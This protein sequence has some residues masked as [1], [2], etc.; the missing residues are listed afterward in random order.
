MSSALASGV[1]ISEMMP[2]NGKT[3]H[4][5]GG[6]FPD[7]VEIKNEA[8]FPVELM[9]HGL[10]PDPAR[11]FLFTFP[12]YRLKPGEWVV[13]F[14]SG[15]IARS[16]PIHHEL[17]LEKPML[18]GEILHLD[19]SQV[20][21]FVFGKNGDIQQWLDR[22]PLGLDT[23]QAQAEKAPRRV[24]LTP[25]KVP[26]V[27]FDGDDD[28]LKMDTLHGLRTVFWVGAEHPAASDHFRPILGHTTDYPMVR[29]SNK[30]LMHPLH[31]D[32][33][34][35][36]GVFQNGQRIDALTQAAPVSLSL[37]RFQSDREKHFNLLGSDRLLDN[38][39]WHGWFSELLLY[40][41]VL[42]PM[43]TS[44]IEN[45]LM[46]RWGLPAS[47][48]HAPFRIKNG[49]GILTLSGPDGRRLDTFEVKTTLKDASL[50]RDP[51]SGQVH[52][53]FHP[54][55][56]TRND[57][58]TF[59]GIL[60]EVKASQQG[61]AYASAVI[62]AL[63]HP[64][65][66]A[67]IRYTLDGDIPD[68]NALLYQKPLS[69]G[70]T[71]VLKA[72]AF[73]LAYR[74]GPCMVHTYLI[75][76]PTSIPVISLSGPPEEWFSPSEGIY[77]K[78]PAASP[79]RPY[80]GAN[81]WREWERQVEVEWIEPSGSRWFRQTVGAKIHGAWSRANPQKS[82]ALVARSS[83][84]DNRFRGTIFEDRQQKTFKQ[85]L[86]RNG[87][88]DWALAMLRDALGQSFMAEM[89]LDTQAYRPVHVMINGDYF[90]LHN[91]RERANE[92]LL[93]AHRGIPKEQIDLVGGDMNS[94]SG[95]PNEAIAF[96]RWIAQQK[97]SDP[98]FEENLATRIDIENFMDYI[99]GQVCIDNGDWPGNNV[100]FWR[101]RSSS[102]RWRWL[103]YDLDGGFDPLSEVR[104]FDT[105]EHLLESPEFGV[106]S[107]LIPIT[108]NPSLRQRFIIR[109]QNHL[110]TVFSSSN[111]IQRID[112][113]AHGIKDEMPYHLK[114]WRGRSIG[115]I[116]F[117]S[118]LQ[119][120]ESNVEMMRRFARSREVIVRNHLEES[121]QLQPAVK[122]SFQLPPLEMGQIR[123]NGLPLPQGGSTPWA[124]YFFQEYGINIS[125]EPAF[126]FEFHGWEGH[127]QNDP[128]I[129]LF[130]SDL[131]ALTPLFKPVAEPVFPVSFGQIRLSEIMYHPASHRPDEEFI[132]LVNTDDHPIDMLGWRLDRGV[133]YTFPSHV[134]EPG[135]YLVVAANPEAY[136]QV[137]PG[138]AKPLGPWTGQLSNA[139]E[140]IRLRNAAN[141][142]VDVL[143]YADE[144]DWS[145]RVRGPT[146][147]GHQGWTWS[148]AHDGDGHS[149][150]RILLI[151][152]TQHPQN[153]KASLA[154]HG[155]PG[156]RNSVRSDKIG[157]LLGEISHAPIVPGSHQEVWV[158][159][160]VE[161]ITGDLHQVELLYRADGDASFETVPMQDDGRLEDRFA[162]D[163][164]Y[165][166][167][168]PGFANQT[169]VEFWVRASDQEGLVR[170][171]PASTPEGQ[172]VNALYQVDDTLHDPFKPVVR[173]ITTEAERS[174][175]E[176]IGQL[177][178]NQTSDAQ[179]NATF[180]IEEGGKV[181]LR[182]LAGLRLRGST[183]RALSPKNRRVNFTSQSPWRGRTSVIF[184]AINVPSQVLGSAL[185]RAAGVPA[186]DCRPVVFL[187]NG[188]NHA[189]VGF[190]QFGCYAQSEP[191]DDLFTRRHFQ[192][193]GNLYRPFG[194]GNLEYLGADPFA[195]QLPGFYHK[196]NHVEKNDWSDLM[197]LTRVLSQAPDLAYEAAVEKVVH[198]D[199][200]LRYFAMDT[201][202]ANME[203]SFA[204]GGAG[205]YAL[206]IGAEDGRATL[207]PYDLDS[208][209]G[210][211]I[212]GLDASIF[213]ATFQE[214]PARFL[215]S[216]GFARAYH[217]LLERLCEELFSPERMNPLLE[218]VLGDWTD[219]AFVSQ[220]QGFISQRR[221][222]VLKQIPRVLS[223]EVNLPFA[224]P[225]YLRYY[226]TEEGTIALRG[227][228]NALRTAKILVQG[229]EAA[230]SALEGQWVM[231]NLPVHG[232]IN[233]IV[234]QALDLHG[235][236][237]EEQRIRVLHEGSKTRQYAGKLQENLVWMPG[238]SPIGVT[239][240]LIIPEGLTLTVLPG[241]SV[242]F[243]AD[244]G[245]LVRG[246][247]Q[248]L[249]TE[250]HRVFFSTHRFAKQRW[251]G[252]RFED[253]MQPSRLDYVT[254]EWSVS[255]GIQLNHARLDMTGCRW[256]GAYNSFIL[257]QYSSLA[258]RG[259][260]FPNVTQGEP[261]GGIGIPEEGY[262]I[263][264]DCEFGSTTGYADIIDFTGGHLPGPVPQ[265]LNN[266]FLG[267]SDDGLDLDGSDAYIEGNVFMGFHKNN[268]S[269]SESHAIATGIYDGVPSN[270]TVVRNIFV[271]NDHDILLKEW[272][273][274]YVGHNTFVGARLATVSLQES[275]RQTH[276]PNALTLEGNII[277]AKRVLHAYDDVMALRPD[278][279][280]SVRHCILPESWDLV[281]GT[282]DILP[283][284]FVDRNAR[285]F[286][287]LP[288]S[289]VRGLGPLG[290]NPG[291]D[292]PGG[293]LLKGTPWTVLPGYPME[294]DVGGPGIVAFQYRMDAGKWSFPRPVSEPISVPVL[295]DGIHRL[296][297]VVQNAA[298]VWL[299]DERDRLKTH[300]Q[301]LA[302]ASPVRFSEVLAHPQPSLTGGGE[303][304][305]LVNLGNMPH[306]LKGYS[307]TDDP[308]DPMRYVFSDQATIDPGQ[309]L[310]LGDLE[311]LLAHV[312]ILPFR[313]SKRGESIHLYRSFGNT[314]EQVDSVDFGWQAQGWSIG[315]GPAGE[316]S[317]NLPSPGDINRL[318]LMGPADGVELSEWSPQGN[319]QQKE[320]FIELTHH[321]NLPV[322]LSWWTLGREPHLGS[323][324]LRLPG[325]TFM[326]PGERRVM[327]PGSDARDL[328]QRLD[329]EMDLWS[330]V[331]LAGN[332]VDR[333]WYA[334]PRAGMSFHRSDP[335]ARRVVQ[336]PPT[337]GLQDVEAGTVNGAPV[338]HEIAADNRTQQGPETT[339]AD[340]LELWNPT[341]KPVHLEGISLSDDL[342][343]PF[344]WS[345]PP[346]IT[347]PPLGYGIVWMDGS[348]KPSGQNTGFSLKS[349]GDQLWMH[350]TPARGGGLL[351]LVDFGVQVP[352]FTIGR[353]S[354]SMQW[355]LTEPSPGG[356]NIPVIQGEPSAIRINEW[357]A[358]PESG[359]DWFELFN[360]SERPIP[361][362]GL[363]LSDDPLDISKHVFPAL[364]YLGTGSA[365]YLLM[366][367][368]GK[369]NR[370]R[371]VAFKLSSEGEYLL[372]SDPENRVINRVNFDVQV[373]G[374]SQGR[375]PDGSE[376][377]F[378]FHAS[379]SPG[380]MNRLDG[381]GDGLPDLWELANGFD[382]LL[383]DQVLDDADGDGASNL[384]EYLAS[385]DPWDVQDTFV[386]HVE[387][388][389]KGMLIGFPAKKERGYRIELTNELG[390]GNWETTWS[391]RSLLEDRL[392]LVE[393]PMPI[394]TPRLF[395]RL[396]TVP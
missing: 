335:P 313:L 291:A 232:G 231:E 303:F 80:L 302:T 235:E 281:L 306:S 124:G 333:F 92:H 24:I 171:W 285:D 244:A 58:E 36:H 31:G 169:V 354:Q 226:L 182:Y 212:S 127:D 75:D 23:R 208:I 180:I 172:L 48:M 120:W 253:T 46:R 228:A 25:G 317:L 34:L 154:V 109:F 341:S 159:A 289:Q 116:P 35:S 194:Y 252:I 299:L 260:V 101:E 249:G 377:Y 255:P 128:Q 49:P 322:D 189:A 265:F 69:I 16:V 125:A 47:Q 238:S 138:G 7:W 368:D 104:Q 345:F 304:I 286:R 283:P 298:G 148:N 163:G 209:L 102:G 294:L 111:M 307:I 215:R 78:G 395:V 240:D 117:P 150:E 380:Y 106:S 50:V 74:P 86:L 52:H 99:I 350:D 360:P 71:T 85:L 66:D 91:L 8:A 334:N 237:V 41:R 17:S 89:G 88:N 310:L 160:R 324:R 241:T 37:L 65:P 282:N 355:T 292:I 369:G 181:E 388:T 239:S 176:A 10:S 64:N 39:V 6:S 328:P 151:E 60:P 258:L 363:Q 217:Q 134:L 230:W 356:K 174:E 191:W 132:E 1:R 357:M 15:Q 204:N 38:R 325:L 222:L 229:R 94:V 348:R 384:N 337:P 122:V 164:L 141:D 178:W 142:T 152:G 210:M 243:A 199:A 267:G 247:L 157:P 162:E 121:F 19:A 22:G 296:E 137:Y 234:I 26:A 311:E 383:R 268:S 323:P 70:S 389:D 233:E 220:I 40:N 200:W 366:R 365:A 201:L 9:G 246:R 82:L 301:T 14:C 385:T 153:W 376:G 344:K 295:K 97:G 129:T 315:R 261:I 62:V 103:A 84:G 2:S 392:L 225:E 56:G 29:G 57:V 27:Y 205:D 351:D 326:G 55:P 30:L 332:T 68:K 115:A 290:C 254:L 177:P 373:K 114:R 158:S 370:A 96:M 187:E 269:D 139:T 12:P 381:D 319:D 251:S 184:N 284:G 206:H 149:L 352:G 336:V 257:S 343:N 250:D 279:Q 98:G 361:L 193:D 130:P 387:Y 143:D 167:A 185:F 118:T 145:Q 170:H 320:G 367:A 67:Q 5:A 379:S 42:S 280:L 198:V 166:A 20:D 274:A 73:Q 196:A 300:W 105:L 378:D 314:L 263:V 236:E 202:L 288:H 18:D 364:S 321:G 340:W 95:D 45:Y 112:A 161:S 394:D 242:E 390:E 312:S 136:L 353:D 266:R 256:I 188:E 287:L 173:V 76:F 113:F 318:A 146:I 327:E 374:V 272:S 156:F 147:H 155:T 59:L 309:R 278:F 3:L 329:L 183:S 346:G 396:V 79:L 382:P 342:D 44:A 192:G 43:E 123:V 93:A 168:I 271:D 273:T 270:I 87:G 77:V 219:A 262:W 119:E 100:R 107:V 140:T 195:Y 264:E 126:G 393:L 347:L 305:E 81:F 51:L 316:W 339:F 131:L 221:Q 358:N 372:L 227:T 72:K 308:M 110:N 54:T 144:G 197:G 224:V 21:H 83:Y 218:N 276:P 275:S 4:D 245:L 214:V 186:A 375:W 371:E 259:C 179:M 28:F 190:P 53:T 108:Q 248:V 297:L 90:G 213:R 211:T 349:G 338:F 359:A 216:P 33:W 330:L 11:P 207:L 223:V 63:S 133:D 61:G 32:D 13:V 135:E 362:E 165:G 293:A 391:V 386:L 203:T 175:L 277:D 331:D